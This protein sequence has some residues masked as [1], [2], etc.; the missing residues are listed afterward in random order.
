MNR[1]DVDNLKLGESKSYDIPTGKPGQ[2]SV[3]GLPPH[4]QAEISGG[5]MGYRYRLTRTG[6]LQTYGQNRSSST[7]EG[8]LEA[9]KGLL[10]WDCL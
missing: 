4:L 9:L 7:A 8:A 5:Q 2:M 6:D 10:N 1:E 3:I